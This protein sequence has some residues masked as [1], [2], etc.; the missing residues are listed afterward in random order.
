[1]TIKE[2]REKDAEITAD[3]TLSIYFREDEGSAS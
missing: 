1:M 3:F 2:S